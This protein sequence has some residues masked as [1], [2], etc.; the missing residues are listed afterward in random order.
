[1]KTRSVNM[2]K[3]ALL[4]A[5]MM[6]LFALSA[7]AYTLTLYNGETVHSTIQVTE[8]TAVVLP[9][10]PA[11]AGTR[12]MGW[13]NADRTEIY[14]GTQIVDGNTALYACFGETAKTAIGSNMISDSGFDNDTLD[15][16][17]SNGIAKLTKDGDNSVLYYD[18]GSHHASIQW[19][20]NWEA[21]RKYYI[22]YK[23]KTQYDNVMTAH[24]YRYDYI[25]NKGNPQTDTAKNE[26]FF[27]A[28]TWHQ[29]EYDYTIPDT[30]IA[31]N[32][33]DA[34]SVF[35]NS[36]K[37]IDNGATE[38]TIRDVYYDDIVV[39]PYHKIT[40]NANGGTLNEQPRFVLDGTYTVEKL[41][42]VRKGYSF[43]GWA[44]TPSATEPI[45]SVTLSG[46]DIT[47]YAIWEGTGED[48]A[49]VYTFENTVAG[50]ADG[51]IALYGT[52][53][54]ANH[55]T[56]TLYYGN[57]DGKLSG[58][59]QLAT[60]TVGEDASAVHNVTG[61][62]AFPAGATKIY[63]E[64]TGDGLSPVTLTYDIPANKQ[65]P[66]GTP[67]YRFYAASDLHEG[68]N[69]GN[70]PSN[71]A[72]FARD[73]LANKDITDFILM[74]GDIVNHGKTA[75]YA[76]YESWVETNVF[77][78]EIPYFM[79]NGNHEFHMNYGS[80]DVQDGTHDEDTLLRLYDENEA[81]LRDTCGINID[82]EE[83]K[84][85]YSAELAG[86]KLIF[87]STPTSLGASGVTYA[88]S[89]E[90]L[91]WLSEELYENEKSN[92][93]VYVMS[94]VNPESISNYSA[95]K[96]VLDRHPNLFLITAHSHQN[97]ALENQENV[98]VGDMKTSFTH[99]NEGAVGYVYDYDASGS[100]FF[101]NYSV[102]FFVEVYEDKVILKGKQ[103][104]PSG[105]L[106]VAHKYYSIEIPDADKAVGTVTMSNASPKTGD[107][108]K[109]LVNGEAP[110]DTAVCEWYVGDKL[111]HTGSEYTVV[112]E[113]I[114]AG[115][116]LVV[117]VTFAD[118][119]F[120]SAVSDKA[121]DGIKVTYDSNGGTGVV[122]SE[123][124]VFE[125]DEI[126]L[127]TTVTPKKSGM[128]FV[129][130]STDKNASVPMT[131][132]TVTEPVT[133]YAVYSDKPE[134]HFYSLAGFVPNSL[135]A[136]CFVEDGLLK[137]TSS[138]AGVDI[139]FGR[140]GIEIDADTYKYVRV[141]T[142]A[143]NPTDCIY[144]ATSE[145]NFSYSNTRIPFGSG[146][147]TL[148][149]DMAIYEVD[150]LSCDSSKS[151]W[152]GTVK[153]LRYDPFDKTD[154]YGE[155]DYI[156]FA[157]N[158]GVYG[159]E[160][161]VDSSRVV[162][163]SDTTVNCTV[164]S[165]S[166]N[167]NTLTVTLA[168]DTGYEFTTSEDVM[169]L[170]T[171]NGNEPATAQVV[172]DEAIVTFE[173][174]QSNAPE[175]IQGASIRT[176]APQGMRFAAYVSDENK[177]L[178]YE[179]GFIVALDKSFAS[180]KEYTKLVFDNDES[181]AYGTNAHGITFVSGKAYLADEPRKAPSI[182]L[183]Y[184]LT[185]EEFG[186][187]K[188]GT[189]FTTVL[190]GIDEASYASVFVARPYLRTEDGICYGE[191]VARS[192]KQVARSIVMSEYN[193]DLNAAPEYIQN[194]CKL[195]MD[196]IP[197]DGEVYIDIDELWK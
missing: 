107:T 56:V 99:F 113:S 127:D 70:M 155:T 95:L 26:H 63:A 120:A 38:A 114:M 117:R 141:K 124:I 19:P 48:Q 81:Y 186:L 181:T 18:R 97:L 197:D 75:E 168:P 192:I 93:P 21:G 194:I 134:F 45:S 47:F 49:I 162:S 137:F 59:T 129:G 175:T 37:S 108:V 185:G 195:F 54:T 167:G 74:N 138:S 88:V 71:R 7:S 131:K 12:F 44:T 20:L 43:A 143:A 15:V 11:P 34:F 101:A 152:K 33:I 119:T 28:N 135:V 176:N 66:D 157:D 165:T 65:M 193:G 156:V 151:Y 111:L 125:N 52:E 27:N 85:F 78:Y 6:M 123:Q 148:V 189:Y 163:L 147:K 55:T 140:S 51:T 196:E 191:P 103:F 139:Q 183:V 112:A 50:N 31:N 58:F 29:V 82:R 23:I 149:G 171:V 172:N 87:L 158:K 173:L 146:T 2:K 32:A 76:A 36:T 57:A 98:Q 53:E 169:A 46:S 22:S 17:V 118:G 8:E 90:Q 92:I 83:G 24:N 188:A 42:P 94:H 69:W 39:I 60:L 91:L 84:L 35:A 104:T 179:Y 122:P 77:P 73:I 160:I 100:R 145:A 64:Y 4:M 190:S 86:T 67:L 40:Y 133:L 144:F 116:R 10:P 115:K 3:T 25:D 80:G 96:A 72:S 170:V 106:E 14:R 9:T 178:A 153:S 109:A 89:E 164:A 13:A 79:V 30:Y 102:C 184:S 128:F 61:S 161:L 182:N 166:I 110:E 62:R 177:A 142:T 159:A 105:T 41:T 174:E 130:W 136:S 154:T 126:V 68:E 150:I 180:E 132:L 16:F 5:L 187:D 121:F 1:M